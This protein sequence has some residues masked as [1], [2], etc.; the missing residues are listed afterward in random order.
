[1]VQAGQEERR[2]TGHPGV[3]DHQVLDRRPLGVAEVQ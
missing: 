2:A 1:V 3:A